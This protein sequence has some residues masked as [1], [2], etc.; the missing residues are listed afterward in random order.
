MWIED[1][2]IRNKRYSSISSAN[3]LVSILI[4]R[5][6][7]WINVIEKEIDEFGYTYSFFSLW[8]QETFLTFGVFL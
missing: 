4:Q 1:S 7:E 3:S 8:L 5:E 6:G 2:P